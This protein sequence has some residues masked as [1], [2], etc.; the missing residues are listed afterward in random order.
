M[1]VVLDGPGAF[2]P[3][4]LLECFQDL[5]PRR[6][7]AHS[8]T[9]SHASPTW[10]VGRPENSLQEITRVFCAFPTKGARVVISA[11]ETK[12]STDPERHSVLTLLFGAQPYRFQRIRDD[13]IRQVGRSRR[14]R[15]IPNLLHWSDV[16]TL[17][18][19]H[20]NAQNE[21]PLRF[22]LLAIWF[23]RF[24]FAV[25]L[26][27]PRRARNLLFLPVPPLEGRASRGWTLEGSIRIG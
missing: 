27:A 24:G 9:S 26:V 22:S 6:H 12:G 7:L 25:R 2:R 3:P 17:T 5:T 10:P 13:G 8:S 11:R 14:S 1:K 15:P 18:V 20:A 19:Q 4:N 21:T 23:A 16:P